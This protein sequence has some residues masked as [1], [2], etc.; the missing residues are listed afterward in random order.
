[1]TVQKTAQKTV[2]KTVQKKEVKKKYTVLTDF[3]DREDGYLLYEEGDIYPRDG[4]T[5]SKERI[6]ELSGDKNAIGEPLIK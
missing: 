6:D 2:Q 1:M 4:Y 5:P 3:R